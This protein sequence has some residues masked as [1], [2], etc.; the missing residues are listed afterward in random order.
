MAQ[1]IAKG[2]SVTEELLKN[3]VGQEVKI[4]FK[5]SAHI[6]GKI[7]ENKGNYYCNELPIDTSKLQSVQNY[8]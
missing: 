5:G 3:K 1:E 6:K 8:N 4:T 2:H 7:K